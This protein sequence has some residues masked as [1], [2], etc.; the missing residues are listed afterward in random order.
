MAT[1]IGNLFSSSFLPSQLGNLRPHKFKLKPCTPPILKRSFAATNVRASSSTSLV[2]TT[3]TFELAKDFLKPV[4]GGSIID[5]SCGSG[6]ISRL[7][8]RNGLFSLVVALAY[9]ENMLQQCYEFIQQEDNIDDK[10]TKI[11]MLLVPLRELSRNVCN[12]F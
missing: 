2:D 10:T 4:Y 1:L 3:P 5:A 6:L 7:F 12:Q 9:S 11:S 8:P